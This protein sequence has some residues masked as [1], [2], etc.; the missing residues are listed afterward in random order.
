MNSKSLVSV[1]IPV[2]NCEK[3]IAE[4]IESILNQTYTNLEIIIV[5]DASTDNTKLIID[6]YKER[7]SRIKYYENQKNS[8]VSFS[9]NFGISQSNGVFIA[10]QDADDISLNTRIEN[11]VSFFIDNPQIDLLTGRAIFFNSQLGKEWID[12]ESLVHAQIYFK[13][14]LCCPI[15]NPTLMIKKS[16]IIKNNLFYDTAFNGPEDYDL[17][18]K[19][20]MIGKLHS[21]SDILIKYRIHDSISRLNHISKINEYKLGT[22]KIRSNFFNLNRININ[23]QLLNHYEDLFYGDVVISKKSLKKTFLFYIKFKDAIFSK[24]LIK[25]EETY[26]ND[27]INLSFYNSIYQFSKIGFISFIFYYKYAKIL[28]RFDYKKEFKFLIKSILKK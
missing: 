16:F 15:M 7:D 8:G 6:L 21:L 1:I 19:A 25:P 13:L 18:T 28:G 23:K 24:Q 4:S 20:V 9:T 5:N 17:F 12:G 3:Y 10:K 11:Q 26:I 27:T 2:F 14:F 22:L